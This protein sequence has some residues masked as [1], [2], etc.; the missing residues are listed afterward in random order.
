MTDFAEVPIS[1][2]PGIGHN[3]P[4]ISVPEALRVIEEASPEALGDAMAARIA[5][6]LSDI[7]RR[8]EEFSAALARAPA[9]ID[10]PE[11]AAKVTDFIT[12]VG[13]ALK[14]VDE[15]HTGLKAPWLRG[16]RV[17][18]GMFG[19]TE[20]TLRDIRA[21]LM[22]RAQQW[23]DRLREQE[24]RRLA[25][26]AEQQ[27][28]EAERL[29]QQ[30]QEAAEANRLT[31]ATGIAVQAQEAQHRA[32]SAAAGVI[33]PSSA[34]TAVRGNLGGMVGARRTWAFEIVDIAKLPPDCLLPNESLIR[35]RMQAWVKQK[36]L[37]NGEDNTTLMP[38]VR[39]FQQS[40][41]VAR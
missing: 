24:R 41:T 16:G 17:V 25:D 12:L 39:F 23:Q 31:E 20:K 36:A 38:G 29:H 33:A 37:K 19:Q 28:R 21:Q 2:A 8:V 4:P 7:T 3:Q 27:R 9:V 6:A 11:T 35:A 40:T 14:E 34:A 15:R 5:E 30:A 26:L 1:P 10:D 22:A 32:D 18:D 13:S